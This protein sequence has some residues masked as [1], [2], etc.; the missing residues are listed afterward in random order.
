MGESVEEYASKFPEEISRAIDGLSGETERAVFV[1]LYDEGPLAFTEIKEELS[2]DEDELHQTTLSNALSDLRN[3]GLI[4]KQ[5]K[6]ADEETQFSSYYSLSEYGDR[7]LNSLLDTLG[8]AQ[9]PAG[10]RRPIV[11]V[12][13]DRGNLYDATREMRGEVAKVIE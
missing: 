4:Q 11:E 6:E 1:L 5:V 10:R 7:F 9:G 3:G 2:D 8:N 13:L 12:D